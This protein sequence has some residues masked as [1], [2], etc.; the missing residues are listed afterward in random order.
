MRKKEEKEK[1]EEK[2][3]LEDLFSGLEKVLGSLEDENVSIE[4]AFTLYQKGIVMV[5]QCNERIDRVEKEL[6]LLNEAGRD[7]ERDSE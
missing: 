7:G 6:K 3:S 4:D 2:E 1:Q 5:R